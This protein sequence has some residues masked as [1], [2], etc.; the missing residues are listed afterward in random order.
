MIGQIG[1]GGAGLLERTTARR[2]VSFLPGHMGGCL[3]GWR[4]ALVS[5]TPRSDCPISRA[6]DV[7]G[8]KWSLL[9]LRDLALRGKS[10][11]R[12]FLDSAEGIST[13]ILADRLVRLERYGL[14][15]KSDDPDDKRQFRYFPTRKSLDLLP[16]VLAMARWSAKYYART[17]AQNPFVKR[18][19][20]DEEGFVRQLQSRFTELETSSRGRKS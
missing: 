1:A 17:V 5:R 8:D 2:R 18:M 9:I 3:H 13:N 20:A 6:L 19:K 16:V 4:W 7:I 14:I 11:Y 12:E 10:R 15:S